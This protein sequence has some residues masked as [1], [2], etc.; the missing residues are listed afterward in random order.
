M[1]SPN[2]LTTCL[3]LAVSLSVV[4]A[5]AGKEYV[6]PIF[7]PP[8]DMRVQPKPEL[9]PDALSSEAALD[10]HDINLEAWGEA[11]WLT[12]GRICRWAVANGADLTFRC[13][14]PGDALEAP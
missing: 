2:S 13:P 4:S 6:T 9:T 5:C 1:R 12:V 7:P 14:P 10:A 8:A 3:L 11:G